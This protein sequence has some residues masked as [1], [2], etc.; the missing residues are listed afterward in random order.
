[1]IASLL[2]CLL[3][4]AYSVITQDAYDARYEEIQF[5]IIID[6]YSI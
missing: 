1:M 4:N 5:D 3:H 2:T 6:A